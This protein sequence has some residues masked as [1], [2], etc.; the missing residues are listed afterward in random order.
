VRENGLSSGALS[1]VPM[2]HTRPMDLQSR[3]YRESGPL[4]WESVA[5]LSPVPDSVPIRSV[6]QWE[7]RGWDVARSRPKTTGEAIRALLDR[8]ANPEAPDDDPDAYADILG[9]APARTLGGGPLTAGSLWIRW[10]GDAARSQGLTVV[11]VPGAGTRGHSGFRVVG[12]VVGH[13]TATPE[14]APGDYPSL[15]VVRDGR[16]GLVGPLGNL[17]LGR[18]GIVYVIAHGVAWH[19]GAS[20]H[21]GFTDLNDEFIGIE[22]E[23]S[24][25][26]RW[27]DEMLSAYPRLVAGLL[28]YMRRGVDRYI[29][30]RGCAVPAGRKP[31]P[32]GISD[33]WMRDRATA[34]LSGGAP[35]PGPAVPAGAMLRRGSSGPQV[36]QLQ[37]RLRA[38]YPTAGIIVDDDFG[39][40]TEELVIRA[41]VG[42][43]PEPKLV[44][45]GVVGPATLRKLGL[46]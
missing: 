11:E 1:S 12:G 27:S 44:G 28:T 43:P 26:G 3:A 32:T 20:R 2:G 8:V 4:D 10:M 22:A 35:P 42:T 29:S 30:H 36:R 17:G 15:R 39:P 33:Q 19:A 13:Q 21:A 5:D 25:D 45:D 34:I 37:E 16:T 24:G 9:V 18:K 31:D 7:D 41:Q 14:N 40:R 46:G 38:W 23:D 6:E